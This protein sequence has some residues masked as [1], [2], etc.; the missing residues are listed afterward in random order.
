MA[1]HTHTSAHTCVY[2]FMM[3][4]KQ[5]LIIV[6]STHFLASLSDDCARYIKL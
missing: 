4:M 1:S 6:M 3:H 2:V 5:P